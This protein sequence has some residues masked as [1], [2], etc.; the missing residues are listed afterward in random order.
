MPF[1]DYFS[2]VHKVNRYPGEKIPAR[3]AQQILGAK[4]RHTRQ[5]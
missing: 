2:S 5:K 1:D 3:E 4:P